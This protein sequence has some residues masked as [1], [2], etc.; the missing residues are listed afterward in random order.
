MYIDKQLTAITDTVGVFDERVQNALPKSSKEYTEVLSK[1]AK[2]V[3]LQRVLAQK[4]VLERNITW[5]EEDGICLE[6][7]KNEKSTIRQ[8]GR[9]AFAQD[10]IKQGSII[11]PVPLNTIPNSDT[12]LMYELV[13]N[14]EDEIMEKKSDTP[15]GTQLILNYCF[16]HKESTML[17]CP[18]TSAVL[19]NHCSTRSVGEGDCGDKGPNAKIQWATQWHHE[20]KEWR[21]KSL[22]NITDLTKEGRVGLAFEVVATRDIVPGEEVRCI[23]FRIEYVRGFIPHDNLHLQFDQ[24]FIS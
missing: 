3:P 22:D 23:F 4:S 11:S 18:E 16:G 13:P 19:I 6:L 24:F 21:E 5:I 7:I 1:V 2:K 9:G 15:I 10:H 12:L 17:L 20:T 14:E 8:A